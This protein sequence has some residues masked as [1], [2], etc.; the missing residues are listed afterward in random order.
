MRFLF[1]ILLN[2]EWQQCGIDV[3]EREKRKYTHM[4]Y[5]KVEKGQKFD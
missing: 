2:C 4:C 3:C 1:H 5:V